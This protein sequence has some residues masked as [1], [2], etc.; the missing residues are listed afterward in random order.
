MSDNIDEYLLFCRSIWEK[1]KVDILVNLSD[2]R[3]NRTRAR[4]A[5]SL[6]V[7]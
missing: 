1:K 7:I 6:N 4:F 3:S 2:V 5:F